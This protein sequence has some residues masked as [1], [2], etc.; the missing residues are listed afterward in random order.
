VRGHTSPRKIVEIDG[1]SAEQ[2]E[3]WRAKFQ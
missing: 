1:L 3:A 2:V